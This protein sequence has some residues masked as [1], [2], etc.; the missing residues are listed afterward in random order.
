M[1]YK[2]G[3]FSTP[4]K[5]CIKVKTNLVF[6]RILTRSLFLIKYTCIHVCVI[7]AKP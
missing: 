4:R 2:I 5:I 1:K 6:K 3:K 7:I